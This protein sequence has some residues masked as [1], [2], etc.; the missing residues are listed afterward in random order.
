MDKLWYFIKHA[1]DVYK[2]KIL[3]YFLIGFV[4][5][6]IPRENKIF[7][8][9]SSLFSALIVVEIAFI[10]IFYSDSTGTKKA[11][12]YEWKK[13]GEEKLTFYYYLLVKN[14]HSL[15]VKF[16][17]LILIFSMNIY[18]INWEF[19]ISFL[20]INYENLVFSMIVYSIL[21]TLDLMLSM[22]YFLWGSGKE[23]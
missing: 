13:I 16:I 18:N 3:I 11:K 4:L 9:A 6:L 20:V 12:E 22:Y 15:I 19:K 14:Y 23:N 10:A 7:N 21:V 2:Y 1:K 17:V 5:S 8:S